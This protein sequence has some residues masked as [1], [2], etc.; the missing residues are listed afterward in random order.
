MNRSIPSRRHHAD[1]LSLVEVSGP[2]VSMPVLEKVFPQGLDAHEPEYVRSLR[3]AYDEWE[4]NQSGRRPSTAIH[5]AWIKFV[6]KETLGYTDEVLA[7][8]QAIPAGIKATVAEHGE[9]LR[10]N[11]VLRNPEDVAD[12]GNLRL[13]VQAYPSGQPLEKPIAGRHWK[14]SPATRMMELLHQNDV[15]L[16]LV[17]NGEQWMLVD[18]P[19][20][21]TTGFASWYAW[22]WFEQSDKGFSY[23][24]SFRSLLAARRFFGVADSETLE[25]ILAE[26]AAHQQEVT[27]QLGLQVRRAVEVLIQSLDRADQDDKLLAGV[28]DTVLYEAAL[29][30]MMRL[31]FLFSAEERGLLLLGDPL[32]DEHYAVST[33]VAQLQEV[34]DQHGEEVLERRPD[35]WVRLLSTFR[36]VFGGVQHE[37]MKLPAYAGNLFDPD[38]FPFLEGRK[39]GTT[40]RDTP[41]M[42]LPV[43]NRT[44]L[45]LLRSLQYLELQG[46][47]RRLSFRALDIEQ[48]GHVYEG[49]LDHT[50]KRATEPVLGLTGAKGREPEVPLADLERHRAK[51]VDHLVA[52]VVDE[53]G[54]SDSA[55]R[56]ALSATLEKDDA[57]KLRAACA[58][59]EALFR[60]VLPFGGLVRNDTFDRPVVIRKGSVYVTEGAER[61]SSGT[62]YTARSLTEPIVQYTLE[63]LVYVGPAE[64]KPKD[65]W[66]LRPAK[67]LLELKICDMACGSGAFLVQACRYLSELLGEAWEQAEAEHLAAPGI[68][69][70]GAASTGAPGETLIP[71]E[72]DE[73]L[74][75]ARRLIAQRCLYGVD[76]NPLA[77]EMAKLSLWLLTL[78]KDK[79]FTF[80]DHAIRSGDS[81]VGLNSVEQLI[82]F[83]LSGDGLDMPILQEQIKRRLD[84]TLLMRRQIAQRPDTTAQ[85]VQQKALML[86]NAEEQSRRLIYAANLL[87]AASWGQMNE[88]DR[89]L[90]LKKALAEVEY[91]FKEL[92]VEQLDRESAKRLEDVGCP[93]PFH[94]SLEF[95]EVFVDRGGFDAIVG[96]PP[97]VGGRRIRS[98]LGGPYL[99]Y[100]TESLFPGSSGNADLCAFFFRRGHRL[101]RESGSFGLL[102]TNTI[103]QGDTR[104]TGLEQ[105]QR[106]GCSIIRA[107]PSRPWPG[108]ANL[109][110]AHVW[111][112]NG[113]WTGSFVL[114]EQPTNG[115][116][117]SLTASGTVSGTPHRLKA[118][119]SKSFQGS[120]VLGM[121]FVLTNEEAQM[122]IAKDACNKDVLFPYLNGED[123]NSRPDQSP[124]RW[125]IN[126]FDWPIEKAMEYRD[127]FR[128]VEQRVK[129]ERT[130]KNEKGEFVL[131]KP[132]PDKWW[133]YADKRP[134]LYSLLRKAKTALVSTRVTKYFCV[135]I[136][137]AQ[138]VFSVDLAVHAGLPIAESVVLFSSLFE[139]W[140]R[141][142]SST[143]E[144][145]LRFSI[146]DS[147]ETFPFPKNSLNS[148]A[149]A[150]YSSWRRRIM[151]TRQE[152]LTKTYNRFHDADE[153]A[154][155]IQKLRDLHFETDQAVVTAYGWNDL[156]LGH[157]FHENKQGLRFTISETARREVLARLLKLNHER[158]AEEVRLGLH[159]KKGRNRKAGGR[160]KSKSSIG[161]P[162]FDNDNE[163][164]HAAGDDGDGVGDR[165]KDGRAAR[166]TPTALRAGGSEA[167]PTTA[168]DQLDTN[169]VMAA[170]RQA[171]RGRGWIGREELLKE[172]SLVLGYLRLGPRI[173]EA[174]RGHLRAAIRRRIVETDG[175]YVRPLTV[176]MGDYQ[177]EDLRD[178]LCSVMRKGTN[179]ER[180]DVIHAVAWHLGFARVTDA[181]RDALKSAINSAIRQ[182]ILAYE[183]S[184]VWRE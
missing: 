86:R 70:E 21:E 156:N 71:K 58:H 124:S 65:E 130:R 144:T 17:T 85:D 114:D 127:C 84:A 19:R 6:L 37:R 161:S 174:L 39:A 80:L 54:R 18:A 128:I 49:L 172:A 1:W 132:L 83:S 27:D 24:R 181:T 42:P 173:E 101:V 108:T 100:L 168:I 25:A 105:L 170:F 72:A 113:T 73:R 140:V 41:A 154:T 143:M 121:G 152:G 93:S 136:L 48:I 78:A 167:G 50:A 23:F 175:E 47:A 160:R 126:F 97:F 151:L 35:A 118:N 5:N 95:P 91:R 20:G 149:I 165:S 147:L 109:E 36:A 77:A 29:T 60:R 122:L 142:T 67:Q 57:D 137:P 11:F 120:I 9:T 158:Y 64:G 133:I 28:S 90:A 16:G 33:L 10:P 26:S 88:E 112:R 92:P 43:N 7:E 94:W 82:R 163:E 179:Y 119:E 4:D 99:Q 134:E 45:H 141:E 106:S 153:T 12:A 40:W 182:G 103:A 104:S 14:A 184:R 157:G 164:S 62:Y 178:V 176:T 117:P 3:L 55:V 102:A 159:D 51:S 150:S 38:R 56:R 61:R 31:V 15:R 166:A 145:R 44:V 46:E 146:T 96:N 74:V 30:V 107:V 148:E 53:T 169:E 177:L 87:L 22:L 183:G 180:D 13:L 98:T 75:Y 2:F 162:L 32:Y 139:A 123:L 110:V 8:G 138:Q 89:A 131:R 52:F 63:P 81:L 66:K 171:A 79:P 34:A 68:T 135:S 129:P 76:K 155:D 115:I 111:V 69:P 116:T 59:D 125:V